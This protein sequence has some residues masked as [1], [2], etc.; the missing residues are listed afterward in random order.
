MVYGPWTRGG[1]SDLR[2]RLP[3][4]YVMRHYPEICHPRWSQYP[5]PKWDRIFAVVWPRNRCIYMM[6]TMMLNIYKSTR[7]GTDG[8]LPYSHTG[9]Y[10]DL[11]KFVWSAAAWN[12][13]ID[14]ETIL[15]DYAKVFFAHNFIKHPHENRNENSFSREELIDAAVEEVVKGLLL[16]E[17]NWVGPLRNNSSTEAALQ[18]WKLIADCIGGPQNNWRVE[19][20]LYKA[21]IDAQIKRKYDLEMQLESEAY[22][23]LENAGNTGIETAISQAK[24]TL[25]RIDS[26]FQTKEEF[27]HEI[28]ELG[29]T[30]KFGDLDEIADNIYT[31]FND[32]YWIEKQLTKVKTIEDIQ[33][34]IHY[35]D[36][37]E[38]GFYDNL[39]V[40]GK[41][42]H[43]Y[44]QISWQ[45]DPG[46]VHSPIEW[47]DNAANSGFRH[48][49]HTH[50]LSR[51]ETPLVMRWEGLEKEATSDGTLQLHWTQDADEEN[52]Y[53]GVSVSEIWLTKINLKNS[54]GLCPGVKKN[55]Y[56]N[57]RSHKV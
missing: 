27:L 30:G 43:L 14:V 16:L 42:P 24:A 9:T 57:L 15:T 13:E 1:I 33:Q 3:S 22:K 40:E 55:N 26:Q 49:Q 39:G 10:N 32:R 36:S 35:E 50:A 19:M 51:H 45:E 34:I 7:E 23:I 41:Q 48:S 5:I 2:E 31:S 54:S 47:V 4:Q 6:P 11:N 17:S 44:R 53:R 12:P 8:I 20:M 18:Q 29:L 56:E 37:G 21:R 28:S 46:F 38:G 25:A 52:M